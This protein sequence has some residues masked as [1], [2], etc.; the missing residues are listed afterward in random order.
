MGEYS[1]GDAINMLMQKSGWKPKITELRLRE[2]WT[3]IVGKPIANH[4]RDIR[5][6][7]SKLTIYTDVAPLKHELNMAKEL[8]MKNINSHFNEKVVAEIVVR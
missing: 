2:E 4:T 3:E 1:I 6:N 5:L 8:L 7:N